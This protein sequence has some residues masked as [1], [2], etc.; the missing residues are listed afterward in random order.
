M[1]WNTPDV[2]YNPEKFGLTKIAELD[3]SSGSYEFN[4]TAVFTQDGVTD[5]FFWAS[6]SGCSCPSPFENY[7]SIESLESGD[8]K[9]V[10]EYL[11]GRFD[12]EN[13]GNY[14][15]ITELHPVLEKLH[16]IWADE[17]END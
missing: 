2:Y 11:N 12:E 15:K 8:F 3:F 10:R 6:D 1:G 9:R 13:Y 7:T 17:W 4:I 5:R 14:V 16:R